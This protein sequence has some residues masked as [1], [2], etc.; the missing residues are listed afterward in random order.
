M[1][2]ASAEVVSP[3]TASKAKATLFIISPFIPVSRPAPGRSTAN[4]VSATNAAR[5]NV[6]GFEK[7][8]SFSILVWNSQDQLAGKCCLFMLSLENSTLCKE[9]WQEGYTRT[10]R[11]LHSNTADRLARVER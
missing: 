7:L 6:R 1:T 11:A 4:P 2:A 10:V 5:T 8:V 3:A 9:L